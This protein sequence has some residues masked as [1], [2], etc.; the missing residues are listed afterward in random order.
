MLW[1]LPGSMPGLEYTYTHTKTV[2]A[3]ISQLVTLPANLEPVTL[4]H[5][6]GLPGTMAGKGAPA[7][8][9]IISD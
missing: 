9:A 6:E 5:D 1:G 3:I 2:C 8:T 7:E 4:H